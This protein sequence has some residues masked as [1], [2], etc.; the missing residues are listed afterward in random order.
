MRSVCAAF[1]LMITLVAAPKASAQQQTWD[2]QGVSF[3]PRAGWCAGPNIDLGGYSTFVAKP[4]DQEMP[5]TSTTPVIAANDARARA[6]IAE[7]TA[8]VLA[9]TRSQAGQD[10]VSANV[11]RTR[12]EC[13]ISD[14]RVDPDPIPGLLAVGTLAMFRCP[15]ES[16]WHNIVMFVRGRDGAIWA[17]GVDFGGNAITPEDVAQVR[18]MIAAIGSQ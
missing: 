4:C 15:E 2:Y 7:L 8:P 11:H 12:P 13:A 10:Q 5:Q 14:Y 16:R 3:T 9:L 18:G 17:M 1:F 6:T